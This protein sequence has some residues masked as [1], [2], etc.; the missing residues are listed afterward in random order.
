ML[1]SHL[2]AAIMILYFA[3]CEYCHDKNIVY[4][5]FSL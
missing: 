4:N 3:K 1:N 5:V 2:Y